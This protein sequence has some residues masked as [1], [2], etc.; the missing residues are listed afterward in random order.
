M[1]I[2]V[3]LEKLIRK[4]SI[5]FQFLQKR[6]DQQIVRSEKINKN[7]IRKFLPDN[8][9]IIDAGAHVGVDS[10]EMC[11]IFNG[12]VIYAF[13]PVPTVFS[14]LQHNTRHY[15]AIH[16][17]QIALSNINGE[18]KMY[19]SS[20]A[21]D[22]SSSLLSPNE[23]LNDHPEVLFNETITVI[24]KT[25]DTWA[26]EENVG[27]VDL[28]WLDMQG[29]EL[30]VMKHSNILLPSVSVVHME[31]STRSTYEG[32]PFYSEVRLWMEANGFR[33]EVEAIPKGWDMGNVLFVR[34]KIN[35][36]VP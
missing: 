26:A 8:P 3:Y 9:V 36:Q 22:G 34:E 31:V 13:E 24:T 11:R 32:V 1:I 20:G 25:L 27:H 19:V 15:K 29:Y 4:L 28:L 23:H 17:Y 2:Q 6:F 33:V 18:Q 21:S 30:E 5:E 12:S 14:S 10:I 7:Y 16:C 35:N